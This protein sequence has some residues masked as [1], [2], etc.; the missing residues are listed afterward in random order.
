V[1]V[2]TVVFTYAVLL[3]TLAPRLL[4]GASWAERAP[5]LGIVVWQVL[6]A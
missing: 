3:C 5:R 4:R 1:I 2:A 6:S